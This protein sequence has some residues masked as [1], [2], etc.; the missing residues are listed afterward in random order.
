MLQQLPYIGSRASNGV[1][2]ITTKKGTSG[3]P[4][5]SFSSS[6]S[7]GN[8]RDRV[9]MM[10][11]SEFTEFVRT[12]FPDLTNNLGIDDPNSTASDNPSTPEIRRSYFI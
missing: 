4:E 9:N 7:I 10:N 2:I 5:F 8:A 3:K 11:G 6:I 1:I 12:N